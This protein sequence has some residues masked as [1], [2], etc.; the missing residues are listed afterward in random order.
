MARDAARAQRLA[1]A[2]QRAEERARNQAVRTMARATRDAERDAKRRHLEDRQQEVDELNERLDARVT[3]L[4]S[5]LEQTLTVNDRIDFD[6]LRIPEAFPPFVPPKE[7]SRENTP[8]RLESYTSAVQPPGFVERLFRGRKR[9]ESGLSAAETRFSEDL[10]EHE[11]AEANRKSAL[12]K[13]EA[14]HEDARSKHL[15]SVQKRNEETSRF[16]AA[17]AAA[18]PEAIVGY[19]SMVLERSEYP[20]DFPHE[21]RVAYVPDS[22]QLVVEYELPTPDVV[23]VAAEHRYVKAKDEIE[24]KPRKDAERRDLYTD[25]VAAVALRTCHE[26]FEADQKGHVDVVAFNGFVQTIDPATG[27]DIRPCLISVRTTRGEF[28][29]LDLRRIDKRACLRN[30]GAVVSPR[31]SEV[32]PVKPI[33]EFD[34]VDKRFVEQSDVLSDLESRP[35][36]MD[37]D[38][39]EFENLVSNLF[40]RIGL[41]TKLTRASRDGGV[42]VVAFD[43]RPVLGGKVVIQA[44][45]Y[46]HTVGVSAVRDLFGTM[47]NEG[48]NKGILVTTSGFGVDAFEFSKDKPIELIDGG[49]LL[50]LLKEAGIEAR[51][52]MP[53][54]SGAVV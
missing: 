11:A 40:G 49:Q 4:R 20:E 45:R 21:Y 10:Q 42:D 8:P 37:L 12:E 47:M 30:L 2:Q 26:V 22:K 54:D 44:K 5:V 39:F 19:H 52:V 36:L 18:D 25:V 16:E 7:L 13:L 41:E 24:K 35:N 28:D 38:P 17:Y 23:P 27:K 46:R 43:L 32:Q 29:G 50:Y 34:M 51:I 53:D 6:S 9:Y 14:Q 3:E 48:A 15:E 1:L 33:V 31:A